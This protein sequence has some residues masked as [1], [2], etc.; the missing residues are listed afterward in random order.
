MF[1]LQGEALEKLKKEVSALFLTKTRSEWLEEFKHEDFCFTTIND[2]SDIEQDVFLN[3]RKMFSENEHPA[4]GKYK[5]IN[6]PLKFLHN[7][8]YNNKSAPDLGDD[9]GAI[10]G[11]LKYDT[12]RIQSLKSKNVVKVR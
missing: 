12:D 8:F 10:L 11:E 2:L 7:D 5:T 3:E 4:A 1:L 9:T 6:Q